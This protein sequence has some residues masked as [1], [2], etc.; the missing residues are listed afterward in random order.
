MSPYEVVAT[1]WEEPC[2]EAPSGYVRHLRGSVIDVP[3][4]HLDRLLRIGAVAPSR[5]GSDSDQ[6]DVEADGAAADAAA[7]EDADSDA[8]D[9]ATGT[10]D[11]VPGGTQPA[12]SHERPKQAAAKSV[13][14][15]YA[16]ARGMDR[17]Q[18]DALDKREL[19]AELS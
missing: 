1:F 17:E 19:I 16:V 2:P 10:D 7:D 4:E 8:D 12:D 11:A 14:V 13:W 3:A 18:A 6:S 15:D 5:A 9:A